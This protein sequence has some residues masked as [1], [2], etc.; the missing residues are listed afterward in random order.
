V[1]VGVAVAV[2]VAVDVGVAVAVAVPVKIG[3]GVIVPVG[4]VGAVVVNVA[5]DL[6]FDVEVGYGGKYT[7]VF[8]GLVK[9]DAVLVA[10][11]VIVRIVVGVVTGVAGVDVVP[12]VLTPV[13]GCIGVGNE[14]PGVSAAFNQ[15]EFVRMA[16]S[17][18]SIN[19]LGLFVRKSLLGSSFDSTFV[20][21]SQCGAKRS[22]QP[23]ATRIQNSPKRSMKT[24][25][26]QSRL[27]FSVV[28]MNISI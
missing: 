11:A 9:T 2:P 12:D 20:F 4:E 10:T 24:M 21:S 15:V 26:A 3:E 14:A 27:S 23:P 19:P 1:A 25:T 16:G 7:N 6:G 17:T 5:T 8:V 28:L 18:G 22:A 13:K